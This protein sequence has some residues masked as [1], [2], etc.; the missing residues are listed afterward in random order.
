M[1]TI[2]ARVIKVEEGMDFRKIRLREKDRLDNG[3][4]TVE[5]VTETHYEAKRLVRFRTVRK[6]DEG[7][8]VELGYCVDMNTGELGNRFSGVNYWMN[9]PPPFRRSSRYPELN[10]SLKKARK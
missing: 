2:E 3:K 8:I 4:S 1:T 6:N 7:G 10:K 9:I 5:I